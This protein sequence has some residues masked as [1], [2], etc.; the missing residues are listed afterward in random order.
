MR[1]PKTNRVPRTRAGGEWTEA[2]FWG[3]LRSVLRDG[4]RRW[5]P[6]VRVAPNNA[7][8]EYVPTDGQKTRRKWEYQC[9]RCFGWFKRT[10]VQVDHREACGSCS[11][12]E[13]FARF[14]ERLFCEPEGLDVMCKECH[15]KKTNAKGE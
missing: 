8:R 6:I 3:F 15:Q 12:W 4:S 9:S 11:S 1:K 7:R 2:A 13:E 5:P 10:E 14:A